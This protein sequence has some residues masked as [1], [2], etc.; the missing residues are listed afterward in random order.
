ME[1]WELGYL[2]RKHAGNQPAKPTRDL[3]RERFNWLMDPE[4]F[5]EPLP[6]E[7]PPDGN[8]FTLMGLVPSIDSEDGERI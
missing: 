7:E 3:A 2:M 5:P 1:L 6:D 4:N 8:V